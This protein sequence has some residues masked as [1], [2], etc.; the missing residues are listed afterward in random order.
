M[1]EPEVTSIFVLTLS[2]SDCISPTAVSIFP[3]NCSFSA[4]VNP[5]S[6]SDPTRASD[7]M[8]RCTIAANLTS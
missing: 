8:I 6:S 4:S 2:T 1:L 7:D 5:N 3:T